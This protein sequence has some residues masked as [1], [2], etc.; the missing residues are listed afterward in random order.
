MDEDNIKTNVS[1]NDALERLIADE[2]E[3]VQGLAWLH[4]Q[5]SNFFCQ[6]N[7]TLALP[8]I[9]LSTLSGAISA[10]STTLFSD[11]KAVSLGVGGLS[12][13]V[14]VLSTVQSYFA[15]ARRAENH[16]LSGITC[17]KLNHF[18]TIEMALPRKER[19]IAHDLLKIVRE[20][21]SRLL[22]TSPSI[23]DHVVKEF[24]KRF[25]AK[26]P[27]IAIPDVAN[28]LRAIKLAP[29]TPCAFSPG[30]RP[31]AVS[32]FDSKETLRITVGNGTPFA[33]IQK[34]AI[35]LNLPPSP[36]P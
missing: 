26:Y 11:P 30:N 13:F 20:Q 34:K 10:S 36:I 18:I 19:M 29:V 1:Y 7:T 9:V 17:S 25:L 32:S 12:I 31:P 21:T 22:E 5:S 15:Y 35:G 16:R 33:D 28:G 23:P 4:E 2:G 24:Q 8:I 3:R 27:N 6:L 14:G